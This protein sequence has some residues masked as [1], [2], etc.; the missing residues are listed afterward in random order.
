MRTS[1]KKIRQARSAQSSHAGAGGHDATAHDRAERG[2]GQNAT[3]HTEDR[4]T[5]RAEKW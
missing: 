4:A 1:P 2:G 3:A 5:K